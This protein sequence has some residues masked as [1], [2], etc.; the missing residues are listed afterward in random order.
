M[1]WA[2]KRR[3]DEANLLKCQPRRFSILLS[4]QPSLFS[5]SAWN[6]NA[7]SNKAA[8]LGALQSAIAV[9]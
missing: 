3:C 8:S 2:E 6:K 1:D 4:S 5:L 9:S 7:P